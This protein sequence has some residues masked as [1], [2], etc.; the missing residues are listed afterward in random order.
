MSAY[1]TTMGST[2]RL[3]VRRLEPADAAAYQ[4]LLI[5][6]EDWLR[7][8][9]PHPIPSTRKADVERSVA[10]G[11]KYWNEDR[12]YRAGIFHYDEV[13]GRVTLSL[14]SRGNFQN[15]YCG[16]W[17]DRELAGR[18]IAT[19]AIA[20]ALE[21]AFWQAQLHRVQFA[22]MPSNVRS[23]RV[24]EKLGIREEGFAHR[25]LQIA[26]VWEDHRIFA[27]TANEVVARPEMLH[28]FHTPPRQ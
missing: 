6:N 22:I 13:A 7:P 25:Y 23:I 21:W 2:G 5:A 17:V 24:M 18:G 26:G 19:E 9:S 20:V 27:V 15:T 1:P 28:S 14:V 16:Y 4:R 10:E 8:W 3:C 11:I 12:A